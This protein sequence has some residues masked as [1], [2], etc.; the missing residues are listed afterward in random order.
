M[1]Q[2]TLTQ[3]TTMPQSLEMKHLF[4]EVYEFT[5]AENIVEKQVND[6]SGETPSEQTQYEYTLY[7]NRQ[8]AENYDHGIY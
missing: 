8:R 1:K 4:G 6:T 7:I 2:G 3:S 5:R